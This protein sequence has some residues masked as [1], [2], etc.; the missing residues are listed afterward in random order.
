MDSNNTN[1][2]VESDFALARANY[3][4][5]FQNKVLAS[6]QDTRSLVSHGEMIS[7]VKAIIYQAEMKN[8]RAKPTTPQP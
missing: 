7:E 8:L 3:E 1:Y 5:W 6:T 4:R 2:S